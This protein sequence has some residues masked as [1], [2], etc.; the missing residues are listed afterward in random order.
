MINV[1]IYVHYM[2]NK[3]IDRQLSYFTDQVKKKYVYIQG[4]SQKLTI[5]GMCFNIKMYSGLSKMCLWLKGG[6]GL[7]PMYIP[8]L[9]YAPVYIKNSTLH[10][11]RA[12]KN[13]WPGTHIRYTFC[14]KC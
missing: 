9:G 11:I 12:H 5:G 13:I 4:C 1:H 7:T 14:R 8:P 3:Y 6:G 10:T 2:N